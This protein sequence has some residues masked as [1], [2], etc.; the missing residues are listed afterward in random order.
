MGSIRIAVFEQM[1][2]FRAGI[3][4]VLN[5]E[6]GMAVVAEGD[7][8]PHAAVLRRA[9]ADVVIVD[10]DLMEGHL[11]PAGP[12]AALC[13]SAKV[14]LLAF[15]AEGRR[16]RDAFAAGVRG[17]VLKGAGRMELLEAVRDVS[18]GEGYLSPTLAASM[19][20]TLAGP[21]DSSENAHYP[22][23]LT[24]REDQ[25][26]RLLSEGLQNKEIG[27]R[28]DLSE[29]SVKR[30]VTCIFEKLNVRNRVEAAMLSRSAAH[31]DLAG[32]NS[33]ASADIGRASQPTL[34]LTAHGGDTAAARAKKNQDKSVCTA[35]RPA[36][37]ATNCFHAVFGS[38]WLAQGGV[39]GE[40][41]GLPSG[42]HILLWPLTSA[43]KAPP[44]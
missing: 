30:Y 4:Q 7:L 16:I 8:L 39:P 35:L 15:S 18:R 22:A 27:R 24:Y 31:Q 33:S 42:T 19:M 2:L 12:V 1:P 34:L 44:I 21:A 37:S 25:I 26:F 29:K 6:A 9:S 3:V 11:G 17:C 36:H 10:A 41:E 40:P 43:R 28:L 5:A 38:N 23:Q 20:R 14:V 32:E 13:S